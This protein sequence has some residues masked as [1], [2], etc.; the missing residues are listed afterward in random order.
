MDILTLC[1]EKNVTIEL[2]DNIFNKIRD[3]FKNI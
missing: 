3:I 2:D 1:E